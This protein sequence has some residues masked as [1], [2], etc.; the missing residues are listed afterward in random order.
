MT[1][2]KK[3]GIM[4]LVLCVVLAGAVLLY[5]F[6]PQRMEDKETGMEET[7][8]IIVDQIDSTSVSSLEVKKEGKVIYSI[9][10][11]SGSWQF[12]DD[13]EVPLD[14]DVIAGLLDSLDP[15]RAS[16]EF[17]MTEG[18]DL[19]QYGLE[20]PA[21]TIQIDCDDGKSI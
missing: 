18:Q 15:V 14:S 6:L 8:S 4:L 9:Q 20:T 16:R 1:R 13:K 7:E 21:M 2:K 10:K 5:Y 11:I 12:P 17:K 3:N 19:S